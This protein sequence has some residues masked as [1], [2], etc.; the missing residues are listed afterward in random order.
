M[1]LQKKLYWY[2]FRGF[3]NNGNTCIFDGEMR[4]LVD[5][6]HLFNLENLL[7]AIQLDGLNIRD[8]DLIIISHGHPDHCEATSKLREITGA[9]VALHRMEEEYLLRYNMFEHIPKFKVDFHLAEK[10]DLGGIELEVL[11]TPGHSPGSISLYWPERKVLFTADVVFYE[12]VGRTDLLGGDPYAL[13]QSIEKL[14]RLEVEYLLP[15]HHYGF[16]VN[17]AGFIKG[18]EAVQRNFANVRSFFW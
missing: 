1:M 13:K 4:M 8:V 15:G 11:H 5:P 18:R 3:E 7:H 12:G 9:K 10:L 6:G 2:P 17:H 14:A 16:P